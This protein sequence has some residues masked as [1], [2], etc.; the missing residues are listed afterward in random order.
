M[1][2][3]ISRASFI[4]EVD[5]DFLTVLQFRYEKSICFLET[6]PKSENMFN[7]NIIGFWHI[8]P[9]NKKHKFLFNNLS[10]E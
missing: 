9:K 5:S 1:E 2:F 4:G 6:A 3:K 8:K 10:N 7:E